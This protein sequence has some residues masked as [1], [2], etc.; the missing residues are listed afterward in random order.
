MK[1]GAGHWRDRWNDLPGCMRRFATHV[2]PTGAHVLL[3]GETGSG[4]GYLARILHDMSPRAGRPLVAQNCGVFTESLAESKLF[5]HVKGAFT[6]ATDSRGGLVE[7]AAGGTLFLDELGALPPLVQPMLLTF[8]ET[9]EFSRMGSTS[10]RKADVRVIS[11]TNRN[12][13][14]A[15]EER[16]FREDVVA[17]LSP[18]YVV[19]PLRT[20][21]GEIGGIIRRFLREAGEETDIEWK[22]TE[23]AAAR[24]RNH[25]WPGNIRELLS[26]LA[27][28][29]LFA[30][31]GFIHLRLVEEAFRNQRIGAKRSGDCETPGYSKPTSGDE[32]RRELAVA[33]EA[34][35]G[36]KTE[37]ARLLGVHRTTVHRWLKQ[38]RGTDDG[39]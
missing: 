18:R 25:D 14:A 36:N 10:V 27:Y 3:L 2:G 31:S 38:F 8:L 15:I 19:P 5:G 22:V 34:T 17:R 28:G 16:R 30:K 6:G 21:R 23:T 13:G 7:A 20:R 33:L 24:L 9:G 12:L 37:A 26:V 1:S 32:K 11:A 29:K 39:G 4:K 35:N